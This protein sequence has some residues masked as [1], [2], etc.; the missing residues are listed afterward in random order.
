MG[1]KPIAQRLEALRKQQDAIVT[2]EMYRLMVKAQ[3]ALDS[4]NKFMKICPDA[5]EGGAF[6]L[7]QGNNA[8][9]PIKSC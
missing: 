2:A 5:G 6:R 1:S 8:V 4:L 7:Y 9:Y 3:E